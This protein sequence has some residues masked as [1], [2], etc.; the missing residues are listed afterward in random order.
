[1]TYLNQD[2]YMCGYKIEAN[3]IDQALQ[4]IQCNACDADLVLECGELKPPKE[5]LAAA[6]EIRLYQALNEENLDPN[7]LQAAAKDLAKHR[8][9]SVIAA[10]CEILAQKKQGNYIPY[11]EFLTN[12]PKGTM[13]EYSTIFKYVLKHLEDGDDEVAGEFINKT[14]K[15]NQCLKNEWEARLKKAIASRDEAKKA[16]KNTPRPSAKPG[17]TPGNI[18]NGGYI[19][20]DSVL[21]SATD[22]DSWRHFKNLHSNLMCRFINVVDEW[23]YYVDV[24]D[25]L[26]YRV[27]TTEDKCEQLSRH[28]LGF[29]T[30]V[31]Q[32]I[33][34]INLSARGVLSKLE[35]NNKTLKTFEGANGKYEYINVHDD[36]VYAYCRSE[37]GKGE[38]GPYGKLYKFNKNGSKRPVSI[39]EDDCLYVNIVGDWIYYIDGRN[40][41]KICRIDLN[42]ESESKE[43]LCKDSICRTI[44]VTADWIYYTKLGER[45]LF[46]RFP[47][48]NGT[49]EPIGVTKNDICWNIC[50]S[51][52]WIYYRKRNDGNK[53]FRVN[54]AGLFPP[55][56]V[57]FS[58]YSIPQPITP[59][60]RHLPH[61]SQ[62]E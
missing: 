42:G 36:Y 52:D 24:N 4:K 48:P 61:P 51:G 34:C 18:A 16:N 6:S 23:I 46:R 31:G 35:I 37:N 50:T 43:I 53:L 29:V 3:A 1:M 54:N 5:R 11:D 2:C 39:G 55:E 27:S 14:T 15:Q 21:G 13:D 38:T 10:F 17:N 57:Y 22:S 45:G 12:P 59:V 41:Y 60:P 32:D 20:C 28:K 7:K 9:E 44:N 33:Y 19:V 25:G 58:G 47:E 30:V 62:I 8:P 40:G 26:L 56:A 49:E